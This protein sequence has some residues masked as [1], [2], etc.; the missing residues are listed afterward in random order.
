[1][2]QDFYG[3]RLLACFQV[4]A[5]EDV[6]Q[7]YFCTLN[8]NS[9]YRVEIPFVF[10]SLTAAESTPSSGA[11]KAILST[12][13]TCMSTEALVSKVSSFVHTILTLTL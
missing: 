2:R 12:G 5:H 6:E 8:G 11:E 13:N 1:M 10:L 4:G 7:Q 9:F 3:K